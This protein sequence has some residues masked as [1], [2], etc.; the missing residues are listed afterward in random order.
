MDLTQ[1]KLS[2]AEWMNV[3]IPVSDQEK[4]ILELILEGYHNVNLRKNR[5]QS[6]LTFMKIEYTGE[7]EDH[8]YKQ[9]FERDVQD[10]AKTYEKVLVDLNFQLAILTKEEKGRAPV[11]K[12]RDLIRIQSMDQKIQDYKTQLFEFIL[13]QFCRDILAS[14]AKKTSNYAFALYTLIQLKK[15][16]IMQ[17]NKRVMLFVDEMVRVSSATFQIRDVLHQAQ[18]F[19][20]KNPYLLKFT[21]QT[22]FTHQKEIFT[23]FKQNPRSS[24]LVLYTAPTG[25]GKTLSPIGLSEGHRI[26][27]ICAARHVGLALAKSAVSVGKRIAIAFGCE[28]AADIRLHYFAASE[29]TRNRK[30]GGIGKV[31]NSIGDKVEIMICDVQ[32]YLTAMHYMLAF[33]P[34]NNQDEDA[35][36]G[37]DTGGLQQNI[38]RDDD[39]ITYW[40]EPTIT[41]DYEDHS[42][43]AMIK[44]NWAENRISKVVLSCATLPREEEIQDTL[45]DFRGR[46]QDATV[47]TIVSYDCRKSISL[48]NKAGKSVVPHLLYRDFQELQTCVEHCKQNKTLLRYFDLAEIVELIKMVHDED[49][50]TP[51]YRMENYFQE[52]ISEVTMNSI[53]L[54]YLDLLQDM[55]CNLWP[56]IIENLRSKQ[57]AKFRC[58]YDANKL[59]EAQLGISLTTYDAYTLTDGPTIFLTENVEKV[60]RFYIQQSAIP[61]RIFQTVSEK[62]AQNSALQQQ[63]EIVNHQIE[64]KT[65]ALENKEQSGGP[66]KSGGKPGGGKSGN[67]KSNK[68]IDDKKAKR[69]ATNPELTKL[70]DTLEGLQGQIKTVTL[71]NAY[72]PNTMQHQRIW[73]KDDVSALNAFMPTVDEESIR[74]IMG[75]EATDQMKLLLLMGIGMFVDEKTVPPLYMEVMKRLANKQQLF[76]ILASSDYIYGTNYQFCHGFIGKDLTMMT[77]Q[78]TIQAM[79]R[80]GRNQTQQE[81]TVRFRDD[82]M[83]LQLFQKPTENTEAVIMSKLFST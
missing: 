35:E 24:K 18:A 62:I 67:S 47:H 27:F 45:I 15:S 81:Y 56:I 37:S 34:L 54:Y 14:L 83:L 66:G 75:L 78:K 49:A 63:M 73:L 21:D 39:L 77:Q 79:G 55:D 76:L 61:M 26:I 74:D 43:H 48:L 30:S 29:Y 51:R 58:L 12:S 7:I 2:K 8:L 72:I 53:K 32:S 11:I 57:V 25:T 46:F 70:N 6:L 36:Y 9:Y 44:R 5:T 17:L 1:S 42:L 41:M 16:S 33:S 80:I 22:L 20:E 59:Q 10:M 50:I 69:E 23:I 38:V 52:G 3:E 68:K 64:D 19:I 82:D 28:S 60:G 40:D 4:E 31:D 71:D 65:A 13:L